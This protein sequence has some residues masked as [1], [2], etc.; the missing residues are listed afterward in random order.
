MALLPRDARDPRLRI[1]SWALAS[2]V[3]LFAY[4]ST[5]SGSSYWLD[6]GELTAAAVDLD[7][8]HPPG[9]PL[10]SLVGHA[11]TLVPLGSLSM[12]VALAQALCAAV[13]SGFFF[14]AIET[15]VRSLGVRHDRVS[16]PVALGAT[17]LFACSYGWWISAIR[18]EVYA[19]ETMLIAIAVERVVALEARWPTRDL[20][21]LPAA[22]LA[23]G[24]SLANH[25]FMGFLCFPVIAPTLARVYRARGARPL[26]L[27]LSMITVG[28][29]PYLYLPIRAAQH[30]AMNLGDP[31]TLSRIFWVV[32]AQAYQGTHA[33]TPEPLFDRMLDVVVSLVEGLSPVPVLLAL[34]GAYAL[35]RTPGAVR[36]GYVW[37]T[38]VLFS[39]F[40]RGWLGFVRGNPD[41]LGYL[42][43]TMAGVS[44]LAASLIAAAIS[45]LT[46]AS[47][48][49]Q[50]KPRDGARP[51]LV[52]LAVVVA[53]LGLAQVQRNLASVSLRDFHATDD[54][55]D[56]RIRSLPPRA[57]VIAHSPQTLFRHF[58]LRATEH[59]RPDVTLVPMP[60]L[61]YPGMI[62]ALAREAPELRRLIESYGLD[63]ELST[64]ELESLASRRPV[65]VELDV[66]VPLA[67]HETLLPEGLFH[68]IEPAGTT[69]VDQRL[70]A[71]RR[72]ETLARLAVALA[73]ER[74]DDETRSQ[75]LWID[76]N[77][78][79][80]FANVGEL[81][82]ARAAVQ[83]G[84]RLSP[85]SVQL[86]GLRD[87]LA[88]PGLHGHVDVRPFVVGLAAP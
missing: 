5:L 4:V 72:E 83:R 31:R 67:L 73:G 34:A 59:I 50:E 28:L 22:C 19:L 27:S 12:R 42:M 35:L 32:S 43:P 68:A 21:P 85:E 2:L 70:A 86:L 13:A 80:Y 11:L 15:T 87:A 33:I 47:G 1:V 60:F 75:L 57:I 45:A 81:D 44:A 30:P 74:E 26:A 66:R 25:H 77:D 78:A 8:A 10:A 48:T 53:V 24:L 76:Y 63:G 71:R 84:L 3:P 17:W 69:D 52:A 64:S 16:I 56:L 49:T 41:A 37:M 51:G 14:S 18:P 82:G 58:E 65:L 20:S 23:L 6:G 88:R 38:L 9:H 40:G 46:A 54:F 79:L 36:V 61:A 39:F 55:D 29:T 7:V 62:D